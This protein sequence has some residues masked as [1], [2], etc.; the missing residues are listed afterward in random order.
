MSTIK[1]LSRFYFG[2]SVTSLN[3][4]IDFNEGGP[5][6]KATLKVGTYSLTEY[7][8]E[9]QRAL[10]EAGSQAYVVSLNRTTQKITVSAPSN[11]SLLRG[12]GSRI[13]SSAWVMSGFGLGADLVGTNTYAAASI[14]GQRYDPQYILADYVSP[15]HSIVKED[16]TSSA[17]PAGLAQIVSFGDGL[18]IEMNIRVI[19][20]KTG[21]KLTPFVE[22]T[23]GISDAMNFISFLMTKGRVEFIPDKD[24]PAS[25]V[26]CYLESTREDRDGK[27]FTLKNMKVPD[28][29]ETGVLTFR[30]VLI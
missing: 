2:T 11:F 12:T 1:T 19:T 6:L 9:W 25:F 8:A 16:A 28:F 29:Y 24:T 20:N 21:M 23:N 4:S 17:T 22:N 18:R 27:K 10:R 7:A 30:K 15:D 3:R 14:C 5:E 26:K 13:G